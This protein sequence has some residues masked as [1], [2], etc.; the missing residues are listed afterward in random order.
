MIPRPRLLRPWGSA[1]LKGR[2]VP[3]RGNMH[4]AIILRCPGEGFSQAVFILNEDFSREEG[5]SQKELLNQARQAA[6]GFI[7]MQGRR[8]AGLSRAAVFLLG[9][10]S[11][12]M[13]NWAFGLI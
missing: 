8:S 7:P 2:Q 5:V 4:R 6:A 12:M 13:L 3:L 9:A 10:G 11:A 1:G